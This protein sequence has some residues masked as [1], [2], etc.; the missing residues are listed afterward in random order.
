MNSGTLWMGLRN[1]VRK[2]T[3]LVS[4]CLLGRPTK[5]NGGDNFCPWVGA[6]RERAIL[7]PVCPEQL[8]GLPTPRSPAEITGGDG[9]D[10][11]AGRAQVV[12][13]AGLVVTDAYLRGAVEAGRLAATMGAT[14]ALLKARS[15]SCGNRQV[16][17]GS[18]SG[19]LRNGPGVTA[20]QL[21]AGG[22]P[23][24]HEEEQA[25]LQ[26]CLDLAGRLT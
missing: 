15:P 1:R 19:Q 12:T 10:V 2:I 4:A 14:A 25:A 8:G 6:L 20:A 9:Y 7:V 11:L 5:Y 23:V 18:F 22:L 21:L 16:Y 26:T 24:F 17:D 13:V 3:L